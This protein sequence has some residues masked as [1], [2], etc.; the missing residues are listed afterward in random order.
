MYNRLSDLCS[1]RTVAI[2]SNTKFFTPLD[3]IYWKDWVPVY[4]LNGDK[5]NNKAHIN[6]FNKK[7]LRR[8]TC[9]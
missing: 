4:T 6:S 8:N 1:P 3:A 2:T 9:N 5:V 7:Y